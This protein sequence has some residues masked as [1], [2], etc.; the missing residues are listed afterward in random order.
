MPNYVAT[1][2]YYLETIGG[3]PRPSPFYIAP[4]RG[5][6][7]HFTHPEGTGH[8]ESPFE[9][10]WFIDIGLRPTEAA[11]TP[12]SAPGPGGGG[13]VVVRSVDE[14]RSLRLVPTAKRLNPKQRK[15]A[16]ARRGFSD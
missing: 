15:K 3:P 2:S 5:T 10:F 6:K 7:Y 8:A 1:K 11:L 9:S 12:V 16:A 4:S 14:L 13:Y